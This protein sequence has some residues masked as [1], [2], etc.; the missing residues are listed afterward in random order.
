MARYAGIP[1]GKRFI[2]PYENCASLQN[3]EAL[4]VRSGSL[5]GNIRQTGHINFADPVSDY[6]E[7]IRC[8]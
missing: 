1:H 3:R 4:D 5:G 7:A 8:L 6:E 2:L